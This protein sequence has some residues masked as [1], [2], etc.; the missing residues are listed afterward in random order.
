MIK[1]SF[2]FDLVGE[3]VQ[4]GRVRFSKAQEILAEYGVTLRRDPMALTFI[5]D[6]RTV[7]QVCTFDR[8]MI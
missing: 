3:W 1:H 5:K 4:R 6:G 2:I 7:Y 8:G